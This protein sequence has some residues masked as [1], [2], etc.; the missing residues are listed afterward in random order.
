VSAASAPPVLVIELA[1][2]G[3]AQMSLVAATYEDELRLRAWL[4]RSPALEQLSKRV[5]A[6]L[7]QTR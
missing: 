2:E 5:R 6:L 7:E 3:S 4:E 1:L